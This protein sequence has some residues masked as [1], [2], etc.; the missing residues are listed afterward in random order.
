MVAKRVA[1]RLLQGAALVLLLFACTL[2]SPQLKVVRVVDGD[3][4]ELSDGQK[5][6]LIGIDTPEKYHSSKLEQD[7]ER[8][9][10][11]IE[12]IKALGEAA[13]KHAKE[14]AE[15]KYVELAYDQAN[16][17][18]EHKGHYGRTLAYV[19]LVDQEGN[20]RFCVNER[21]IREGYAKA[22]TRYPFKY[23]DRYLK[24]QRQARAEERGLW[25]QGMVSSNTLAL[26]EAG[27]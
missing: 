5:V 25:G 14:L 26:P 4:F 19:W 10:Q 9:G 1:R 20:R 24:L 27:K 8:T 7:A 2:E 15:D 23:K 22:Y 13:S 6:R 12:T 16:A 17:A 21:M 11:D 3:T 18:Q